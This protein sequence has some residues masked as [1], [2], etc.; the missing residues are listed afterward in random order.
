MIDHT[1]QDDG[2][3]ETVFKEL[4]MKREIKNAVRAAEKLKDVFGERLS[5]IGYGET[6]PAMYE[7]APKEIY[8]KAAKANMRVLFEVIVK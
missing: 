6:N 4:G 2:C 1:N 8:S 5:A 3:P 7:A